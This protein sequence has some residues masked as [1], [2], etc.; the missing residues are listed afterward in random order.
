LLSALNPAAPG[1]LNARTQPPAPDQSLCQLPPS[2]GYQSLENQLYR[3]EI[4]RDNQGSNS[5]TFKWSRD[6]G[7]VVTGIESVSSNSVTVHDVGP[8]D[9]LGFAGGQWVEIVDDANDLGGTPGGLFQIDSVDKA[10]RII[11]LKTT[12][13]TIDPAL[14]PKLRRWDQTD[15]GNLSEGVAI[16]GDWQALENGIQ[17]QFSPNGIFRTGDYWLIPARTATGEIEWPPYAIPNINPEP[18]PPLGIKHHYSCLGLVQVDANGGV[19]V[20]RDCRKLFPPLTEIDGKEP[21]IHITGI[22][23]GVGGAALAND[24]NVSLDNFANGIAVICDGSLDATTVTRATCSVAVEAP[25]TVSSALTG[26]TG[27]AEFQVLVGSQLV[28]LA[29]TISVTGNLNILSWTPSASIVPYLTS[30]LNQLVILKI[31]DVRLLLRMKI[32]GNFVRSAN[33]PKLYLDG[34]VFGLASGQNPSNLDLPSGDGR[35]GGDFEMSWWL[36]RAVK[37][38]GIQLNPITFGV[39]G[40]PGTATIT[41]DG[42]APV[43][44][45]VINVSSDNVNIA[46]VDSST[47]TVNPGATQAQFPFRVPPSVVNGATC[48]IIAELSGTKVSAQLLVVVIQ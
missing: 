48:N 26:G 34:E 9:A 45:L 25:F 46:T 3:V 42:P 2:A 16:T 6:N 28:I 37:L 44:G 14:H 10:S 18:Q 32:K 47:V 35:K 39:G 20:T 22:T 31:S 15:T 11:S 7:S 41:L 23:L 24:S 27:I 4:H 17:V 13:P 21:G 43:G 29:A 36:F 1:T 8:D 5:P 30:L 33:D 38:T 12:P 40:G 19:S